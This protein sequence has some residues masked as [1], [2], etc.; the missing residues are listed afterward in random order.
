[1][2]G[3]ERHDNWP[4]L[5]SLRCLY[6]SGARAFIRGLCS[7]GP[8]C[9]APFFLSAVF[10]H[11]MNGCRDGLLPRESAWRAPAKPWMM[12]NDS[13]AISPQEA[14]QTPA[15]SSTKEIRVDKLP[16][17]SDRTPSRLGV[18]GEASE[19]SPAWDRIHHLIKCWGTLAVPTEVEVQRSTFFRN[20]E[21]EVSA[22]KGQDLKVPYY[23]VFHQYIIVLRYI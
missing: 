10:R 14:P 7:G 13:V 9:L 6:E 16:L 21:E 4:S 19:T 5:I 2:A 22:K 11:M 15:G 8:K 18:A 1:M 12:N 17:T 3:W 20:E 23:T